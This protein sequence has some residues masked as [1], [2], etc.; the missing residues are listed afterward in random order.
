MLTENDS[1]GSSDEE[2]GEAT[3][4]PAKKKTKR[5]AGSAAAKAKKAPPKR[6]RWEIISL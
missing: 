2:I 6:S 1:V 4:Q 3:N 5:V